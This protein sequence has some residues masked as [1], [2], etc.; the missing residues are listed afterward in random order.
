MVLQLIKQM[1]RIEQNCTIALDEAAP[2]AS[3]TE[4]RYLFF[5]V[6]PL[7]LP[8]HPN[9]V[10]VCLCHEFTELAAGEAAEA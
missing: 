3:I 8:Q 7:T 9:V 6:V 1:C 2:D 4:Y 10:P 5:P